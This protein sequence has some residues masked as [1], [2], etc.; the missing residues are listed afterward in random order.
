LKERLNCRLC[1]GNLKPVFALKPSPI[2]NSFPEKPDSG[3]KK[4]PLELMQCGCGHVQQRYVLSGLF[5]DY[6]YQTPQTVATYLKPLAAELAGDYPRAK[7]LEIGCNNGVFLDCLTEVGFDAVGVDPA[8]DHPKGVKAYFSEE[9]AGRFDPVD[10]IV[11]NNVFAHIDDLQS[12]FRGIDNLLKPYGTLVF[13]VQYLV[14]LV[15]SGSFDM[16]YAEHTDYHTL[17][18]LRKF[19]R[20]FGLVMTNWSHIPTHGGSIR[21]TARRQGIEC[22]IPEEALDWDGLRLKIC[23]ARER[24]TAHGKMVAF[25]AAAK[26]ATLIG[27]LGI[28]DQILY[29]VDD[30][31]AKQFRYIPGTDIQVLPVDRLG[32]EKV[33]MCAWNYE[34]EIRQRIPNELVH[35][36]RD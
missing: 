33:L 6:K 4:Y 12:V 7:V 1:D 28:A 35:P 16:I 8:A 17:K 22:R 30:T 27:E 19:L 36:F 32:D 13:E 18:P 26:A 20:R 25:G 3:A 21:V 23:A 24:V 11:A 29:C 31:K 14:D 2:A 5:Q 15:K 34:R 9:S 10:L